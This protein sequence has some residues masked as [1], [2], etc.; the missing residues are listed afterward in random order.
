MD[1]IHSSQEQSSQVLVLHCN[2][3]VHTTQCGHEG[4]SLS[5]HPDIHLKTIFKHRCHYFTMLIVYL[6]LCSAGFVYQYILAVSLRLLNGRL[7]LPGQVQTHHLD[8]WNKCIFPNSACNFLLFNISTSSSSNPEYPQLLWKF[9]F[10][11]ATRYDF[12]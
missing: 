10:R 7:L 2:T 9:A 3:P 6:L 11:L 12:I 1:L 5:E 4:G 8:G